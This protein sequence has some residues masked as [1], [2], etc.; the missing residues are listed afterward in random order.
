VSL[1]AF[2][3]GTTSGRTVAMSL[4]VVTLFCRCGGGGLR[5]HARPM[6]ARYTLHGMLVFRTKKCQYQ[7]CAP[8]KAVRCSRGGEP[9]VAGNQGLKRGEVRRPAGSINV[10]LP[11]VHGILHKHICLRQ[12]LGGGH[13]LLLAV[14]R[15]FLEGRAIHSIPLLLL[16]CSL[17]CKVCCGKRAAQRW[18]LCLLLQHLDLSGGKDKLLSDCNA[19]RKGSSSCH[20]MS[21]SQRKAS[22]Q[23]CRNSGQE[24][25]PDNTGAHPQVL[26]CR[27]LLPLTD[28]GRHSAGA[29]DSRIGLRELRIVT[30]AQVMPVHGLSQK[31]SGLP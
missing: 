6:V 27:P 22:T 20:C 1:K 16:L 24:D 30:S 21:S 26:V 4:N 29:F 2:S 19:A 11:C 25:Q 23:V 31:Q 5:M 17:R 9:L 18:P 8:C 7:N 15:G 14:V 12:V 3:S 28:G 13:S 10:S